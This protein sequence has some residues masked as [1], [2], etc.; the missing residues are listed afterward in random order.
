MSGIYVIY[1]HPWWTIAFI[2]AAGLA[3]AMALSAWRGNG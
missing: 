1:S 3:L 2:L